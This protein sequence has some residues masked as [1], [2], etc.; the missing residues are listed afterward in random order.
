M[1]GRSKSRGGGGVGHWQIWDFFGLWTTQSVKT[2]GNDNKHSPTF[3]TKPYTMKLNVIIGSKKG[4][5]Q[6]KLS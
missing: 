4:A 2:P 3:V 6:F 1:D 5:R